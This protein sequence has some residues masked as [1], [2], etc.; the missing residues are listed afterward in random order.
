MCGYIRIVCFSKL[1][2]AVTYWSALDGA[3]GLSTFSG[4][5]IQ[6]SFVLSKITVK[7]FISLKSVLIVESADVIYKLLFLKSVVI[8]LWCHYSYVDSNHT[9]LLTITQTRIF[10]SVEQNRR[11]ACEYAF[12]GNF[13]LSILVDK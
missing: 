10:S 6:P 11:P 1:L 2:P 7:V 4:L 5:R 8:C 13:T 3:V 12:R 9:L